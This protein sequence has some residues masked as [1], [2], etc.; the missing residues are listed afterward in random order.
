MNF[1]FLQA[2]HLFMENIQAL[3]PDMLSNGT[4]AGKQWKRYQKEKGASKNKAD[5]AFYFVASDSSSVS[6]HKGLEQ[7][8]EHFFTTH[9]EDIPYL[10]FKKVMSFS[11]S[12]RLESTNGSEYTA[13]RLSYREVNDSLL[14]YFDQKKR[15]NDLESA[16]Q[17][18]GWKIQDL[19]PN[20]F[21]P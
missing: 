20:P 1:E 3:N 11:R 15:L 18:L 17:E 19:T 14:S 9:Y 4:G 7:L 2:S 13:C 8:M 21:N 16:V 5:Q 12:I 6:A 10:T